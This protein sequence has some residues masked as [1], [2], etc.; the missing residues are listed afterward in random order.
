M[1]RR[2]ASLPYLLMRFSGRL[3]VFLSMAATGWAQQI[4]VRPSTTKTEPLPEYRPALIGRG[5]GALI[6][7][8]DEQ[9]LGKTGMTNAAV[10][11]T[12]TVRK[13][14]DIVAVA[15]FRATADAQPLE[16]ELR[17]KLGKVRFVPAVYKH[18][19]VDVVFFGT[20]SFRMADGKPHLRIFCNQ[21]D[22][23][24]R[25]E[26]DFIAPQIVIGADS[27]FTG[28][29]YPPPKTAPVEVE[30]AVALHLEVDEN[31]LLTKSS[32]LGED[33]PYLGFA[34]QVAT[35]LQGVRFVPGFRDG[36]PVASKSDTTVYFTVNEMFTVPALEP[37][38]P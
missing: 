9:A 6:N 27:A 14:G 4:D 16:D 7:Q 31:G 29:H 30:G 34:A 24:L 12:C 25:A 21:N 5:P 37:P 20:V 18:T 10:L 32:I 13:T 19:P 35:D 36:K 26:S 1:Q 33:P 17:D 11:F 28:W 38:E 2:A 8:L 22:D 23:E 15:K 3:L